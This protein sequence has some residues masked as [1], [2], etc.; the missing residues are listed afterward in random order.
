[1]RIFLSEKGA[2]TQEY[3]MYSKF[4]Q[5]ISGTKFPQDAAGD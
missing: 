2:E 4:L 1:V 3:W 5:R